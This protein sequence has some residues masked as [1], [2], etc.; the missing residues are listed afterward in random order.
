MEKRKVLGQYMTP[1]HLAALLAQQVP[2]LTKNA[3]DLAAGD[4]SL[5]NAVAQLHTNAKLHGFEIDP[6][7]Y[8]AGK[9]TLPEALI[10]NSD[11]LTTRLPR[12]A[13][14]LAVVGNPP[15]SETNPSLEMQSILES[16]F[17]G[18]NTKLGRKRLELYFLARSL[19]M[20][21]KFKGTVTILMPMGFADGDIYSSYRAILMNCYSLRKV[22]EI[23][24]NTFHATEA[25]TVMLVIDTTL[26]PNKNVEIY[27]YHSECNELELISDR[28]L[29]SGER[30][31][32]RYHEGKIKLSSFTSNLQD[33]GATVV[34]GSFSR[35]DAERMG[36][37][38]LHTTNLAHA[39][40]GKLNLSELK[41][42]A[43]SLCGKK[44]IFAE[45]GDILLARTGS[46][47]VWKPIVVQSGS[48]PITDH[49]FRIRVPSSSKQRVI[50]AFGHPYFSNW[51]ES[52][53]KGVCATVLTKREL[54]TMPLFQ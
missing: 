21:K 15:F 48:L 12:L 52:V 54:L 8:K 26:T 2:S 5:L 41:S 20:A 40:F 14:G 49:V 29:A 28:A 27:R 36:I 13:P 39:K 7:F 3:I 34:R 18:L 45:E 30:F 22:I 43:R 32:A 23:T 25:R 44:S 6:L 11:G 4:C 9:K 46:R 47:V 33:V 38:A 51:L 42:D 35:K 1:R 10:K 31:D 37:N 53:S 17:P 16:A 19:L 24:T 50:E